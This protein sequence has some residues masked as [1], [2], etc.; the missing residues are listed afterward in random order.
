MFVHVAMHMSLHISIHM[1]QHVHLYLPL[2]TS[3][4]MSVHVCMCTPD[5]RWFTSARLT[6]PSLFRSIRSISDT[7]DKQL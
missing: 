2:D 4:R 6:L 3:I 7:F 1:A 5:M